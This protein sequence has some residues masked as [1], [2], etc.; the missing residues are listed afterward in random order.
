LQKQDFSPNEQITPDMIIN[1][2]K[3]WLDSG[4]DDAITGLTG[5]END[6]YQSLDP[7]YGARNGPFKHIR[8]LMRVKNITK[9]MFYSLDID[10]YVTVYGMTSG[11]RRQAPF[12]LRR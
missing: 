6:Y 9:E 8:E 2:I 5:A 4:D 3:D 12:Y 11:R 1:P 7:P 10:N